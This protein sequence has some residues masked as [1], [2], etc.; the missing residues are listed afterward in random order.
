MVY[1]LVLFIGEIYETTHPYHLFFS[2]IIASSP[3]FH[4]SNT[5]AAYKQIQ[6]LSEFLIYFPNLC[7]SIF[8]LC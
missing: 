4:T 6:V 8:L 2:L 1:F 5:S 3:G 7:F